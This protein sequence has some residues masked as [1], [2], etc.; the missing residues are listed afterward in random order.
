MCFPFICLLV[1]SKDEENGTFFSLIAEG[2]K[3]ESVVLSFYG[4][5]AV[6]HRRLQMMI[7]RVGELSKNEEKEIDAWHPDPSR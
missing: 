5:F 2:S 1:G 7:N 4:G 6:C 3:S